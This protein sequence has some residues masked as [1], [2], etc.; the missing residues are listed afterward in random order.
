[1]QS[2]LHSAIDG[3]AEVKGETCGTCGEPLRMAVTDPATGAARIVPRMCRCR[4][5]A[6]AERER[7]IERAEAERK[8]RSMVSRAFT[9]DAARRMT[10]DADDGGFGAEQVATARAYASR[11]IETGG[12]VGYGLLL[13]GPPAGGKTFLSCCV[14]NAALDAGLSVVM[15][16]TP[17]LLAGWDDATLGTCMGCDL[18]IIDDLG[19]ERAT[20]YGQERVYAV[21]DGRYSR[22]RP[23]L[24]STN[25]TRR[26]L[27]SPADVAAARIYGR[28]LECCLPVEVVTGRRRA[29]RERYVRM[30]R[31]LGV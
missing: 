3:L 6:R 22:R 9:A 29:T 4:R 18:L 21:I 8:A 16:S 17:E 12:E 27:A 19:S 7:A 30:K 20:S 11:L 25:L 15:R 14:A 5:D 26:E 1:M 23:M 2:T 13:F 10:F 31:D 24:V 28:V